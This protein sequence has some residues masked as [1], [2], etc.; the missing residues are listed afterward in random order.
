MA[1]NQSDFCTHT[2]DSYPSLLDEFKDLTTKEEYDKYCFVLVKITMQLQEQKQIASLREKQLQEN[3]AFAEEAVLQADRQIN[4]LLQ[5][6]NLDMEKMI[7]LQIRFNIAKEQIASA[8]SE[9]VEMQE[10]VSKYDLALKKIRVTFLKAKAKLSV[11]NVLI[12][13]FNF[14]E[15]AESILDSLVLDPIPVKG[16]DV[17]K[18]YRTKAKSSIKKRIEKLN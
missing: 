13:E 15:M 17:F 2:L 7:S 11:L 10:L 4:N 9:Y 6:N 1:S 12:N 14:Q 3:I 18:E 16:V 5:L 8:L